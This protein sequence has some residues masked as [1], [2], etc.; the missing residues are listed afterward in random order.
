MDLTVFKL[1][2]AVKLTADQAAEIEA[3]ITQLRERNAE[4]DNEGGSLLVA[5]N[6]AMSR[7]K[8]LEQ[9]IQKLESEVCVLLGRY[10]DIWY[11]GFKSA[12]EDQEN[13]N[14][15]CITDISPDNILA[16]SEAAETEYLKQAASKNAEHPRQRALKKI[17]LENQ[18]EALEWFDENNLLDD[19]A[20][21]L[22]LERIEQLREGGE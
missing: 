21:T 22:L 14:I 13:M 15:G 16:M 3:E 18:I 19:E 8:E 20:H 9:N 6:Q 4:L 10:G 17:G 2:V 5:Y 7:V 11:E 12:Q 1:G